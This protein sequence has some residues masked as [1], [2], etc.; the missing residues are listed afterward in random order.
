MNSLDPKQAKIK[1]EMNEMEYLKD[2]LLRAFQASVTETEFTSDN[3]ENR[4]SVA[5]LA[6]AILDVNKRMRDI[7]IRTNKIK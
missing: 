2:G 7:S 6:K 1:N 3:G 5:H 4:S